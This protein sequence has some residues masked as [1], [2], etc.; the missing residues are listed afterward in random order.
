MHKEQNAEQQKDRYQLEK[1]VVANQKQYG[2]TNKEQ[3]R[4]RAKDYKEK[5]KGKIRKRNREN[6]TCE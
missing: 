6:I 5:N 1:K 4:A 3:I 2:D